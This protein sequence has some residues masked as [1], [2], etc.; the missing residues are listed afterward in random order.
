MGS[1]EKTG[2]SGLKVLKGVEQPDKINIFAI[3]NHK[4]IK[5]TDIPVPDYVKGIL[6]GDRM[7]LSRTI[8]LIESSLTKHQQLAQEILA[9]C[10][11]YTG[12]S[13]RIGI[14]G[15]P[16]VGKSTF[17]EALGSSLISE[18]KKVCVLAVDPSSSRSKGS[19]LGDKTRML[20]LS[21]EEN[22]FIR[23]SP[24]SGTLGGVARKTRETIMLCEAAGYD[25][26]LVE[27]VG[28][29]QSE[30][31]VHSMVDFFLVLMLPGAGDE[32]QGIKRGI[33]ELADII[34]INKSDNYS[35][36][37]IQYAE[38][39]LKN[40]LH[41]FPPNESGWIPQV[42]HCSSV[43]MEGI[44]RVWATITNYKND[45]ISNGYFELNRKNQAK[46]WLY[47]TIHNELLKSFSSD[48]KIHYRMKAIEQKVMS[49]EIS[50]FAAAQELMKKYF[51]Q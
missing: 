23:P 32:L 19:I 50:P 20:K 46:H 15:I 2:Q 21:S 22:A 28:V 31:T 43:N 30:T 11:P 16:G 27:T 29:G 38:Q 35:I 33:M 24:S 41:F 10:L 37:K 44:D 25:T 40:A 26:I 17:I 3:C 45:T 42:Q 36:E 14:T 48:K 13:I 18:G 1:K 47:E 51:S 4:Q 9:K 7:L 49:N 12:K 6:Q 8:T 39:I 5:L 34:V